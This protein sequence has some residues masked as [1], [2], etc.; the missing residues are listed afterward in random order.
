MFFFSLCKESYLLAFFTDQNFYKTFLSTF[1]I[2]FP[3]FFTNFHIQIFNH[4][5]I[6]SLEHN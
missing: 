6:L 4:L 1:Y 3:H 2:L 5:K